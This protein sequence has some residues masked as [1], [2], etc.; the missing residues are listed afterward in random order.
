VIKHSARYKVGLGK[1]LPMIP[2]LVLLP[3]PCAI[4]SFALSLFHSIYIYSESSS[5]Y[6]INHLLS[7]SIPNVNPDAPWSLH[8]SQS[9]V[10]AELPFARPIHALNYFR[11]CLC[12]RAVLSVLNNVLLS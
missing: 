4:L 6:T 5:S 1:V 2:L 12:P 10:H 9:V 7:F 11:D 8:V 3:P